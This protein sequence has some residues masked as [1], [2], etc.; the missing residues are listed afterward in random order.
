MFLIECAE[1]ATY[2]AC[3]TIFGLIMLKVGDKAPDFEIPDHDGNLVGLRD[4]T[5]RSD[6]VL[7]FYPADFT[8]G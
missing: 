7:Y 8:P 3:R 2:N 5:S 4:L 1:G 6:F